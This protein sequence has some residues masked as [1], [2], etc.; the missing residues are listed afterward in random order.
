M[1]LS[2]RSRVRRL[3]KELTEDCKSLRKLPVRCTVMGRNTVN[4]IGLEHVLSLT[5]KQTVSSVPF[6]LSVCRSRRSP[7]E[8]GRSFKR[9]FSTFRIWQDTKWPHMDDDLYQFTLISSLPSSEWHYLQRC[10]L[11]NVFWEWGEL[12][13]VQIQN[14]RRQIDAVMLIWMMK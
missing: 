12:I 4:S 13:L 14:L 9:F 2:L 10:Q 8:S 6:K 7:M 1:L 11:P 3:L 5:S